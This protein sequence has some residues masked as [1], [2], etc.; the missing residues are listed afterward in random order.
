MSDLACLAVYRTCCLFQFEFVLMV[1]VL[2]SF[3]YGLM[4]L[5]SF[6]ISCCFCHCF[7]DWLLFVLD[8]R[9]IGLGWVLLTT[10]LTLT[11]PNPHLALTLT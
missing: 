11:H 8:S 2:R 9:C 6:V 3:C 5:I 4:H 10:E 1:C 7:C